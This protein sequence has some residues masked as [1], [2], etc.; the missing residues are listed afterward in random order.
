MTITQIREILERP[1][2]RGTWKSFLKTQFTNN[3]LNVEDRPISLYPN[4]ISDK[5]ISLG[6]YEIDTYSNVGIFEVSLAEHINIT[7]NRVALRNLIKDITAQVSG[8]MVV[9][10]QGEKWRFSYISKRKFRNEDL[11][12]IEDKET[13]PKR[14]T[15]L[16]GKNEKAHTA[17]IRFSTLIEKQKLNLSE[18]LSLDDFEEAFSVEKLSK[19]FFKNYKDTYEDFVQ[20]LTGK[21][22]GK[23]GSRYVELSVGE[24]DWQL[25][26]LFNKEEKQARDFCKRMMGRLVFLY[27]IQKKG[28]LAVGRQKEWGEGNPNYL[29]DLF[30]GS[31]HKD[32]FYA[33][34]LVPLFFN[35]LN[36]E[37]SENIAREERFP[38]LNGGLFDPTQDSKFSKLYLPED[39]FS[40]MFETF[41]N[42]N[43]TIY[44]DAP[45]EHTVAVDPEMLGHIFENLLEDNKDKGAFYTPKEIVHY[46]C[47]ES[48]KAYLFA[49]DDMQFSGNPVA[50]RSIEKV[51]HQ[52]ELTSEEKQYAEKV[53]FK[54]IDALE[55]VRICDPAIGSGA[56]PMG[57]LQEIF[58]AL[59]YLQELKGFKKGVSDADIKKHIIEESIYGVDIDA[60]AVDI[61][62]LRFWLSLVVDEPKPQPL[63]NLDFKIVCAN[64]LI[65]LGELK[66][67]D[68]EGKAAIAVK[69]LE[70]LRHDFFNVSSENKLKL[71][72]GF[73]KIQTDLLALREMST[74]KNYEIYTK[75]NEFNPFEDKPCSWFDASWMFGIKDGFDIVIGNPPY[76]QLQKDGGKLANLYGPV[77]YETFERTGDVYSLFY[78][79]G[80]SLL[81][82]KGV[83]CFITSN[84]WMR[85]HYGLSTR[86]FFAEK[87]HPLLLIDFG[88][89]QVF[90]T[91]TV[92]TNIL[93]FQ[94][95]PKAWKHEKKETI[96]VR[97]ENDYIL[98]DM[99][100][101]DYVQNNSYVLTNL[102]HNSWVVGERDTYDIKGF[103][104][105]QGVPL[106]DWNIVINYGLKT[107]FNEAFIIPGSV[108][109]ELIAEDE[110]SRDV[111]KRVLRGKDLSAW[112]PDFADLWLIYIPWHFPLHEEHHTPGITM[113]AEKEFST[114][115]PAVYNHLLK[116]KPELS[117]RNKAEV[118]IRYEWYALQRFGSNYWKDFEKPKIIFPEI[119][120]YIPFIYDEFDH[121]YSN[122][123]NFIL[124]G[125]KLK[126][127]MCFLNSK[128]F[129]Y[130]FIDN[131]PELQGGSRELRKVFF[132]QIPVKRITEEEELPFSKIVEYVVALKKEK[133]SDHIDQLMMVYFEQIANAMIFELYFTTEF[134]GRSLEIARYI[135]ELH[136][137]D[138]KGDTLYQLR[139]IYISINSDNHPIKQSLFKMLS[140]PQIEVIMNSNVI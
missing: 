122:N 71:E 133:P 120:K 111:I 87:T 63:P 132:E 6:Y 39:I 42:Y 54:I 69:E 29:Y 130:C 96:A 97:I 47:K 107:G 64:T 82:D 83:L 13:S 80:A 138:P 136:S 24:A 66:D 44:E 16:F 99:N 81:N 116:F 134:A 51:I 28:W 119:T 27:F 76:V 18:F 36:N 37:D 135:K 45:D 121:F 2:D 48:L 77:K 12:I 79:R 10:V 58:N 73:R 93:I 38:Y 139:K 41:N 49:R 67:Y 3:K 40:R 21:R 127:L 60:G 9:F 32:D 19:E 56:F 112:Y 34:E 84:K 25:T 124:T 140:I 52:Q 78:E 101:L 30:T 20:F 108:K 95:K 70:N 131:F 59:I 57:I 86:R 113:K 1:Y 75:L 85:A 4:Q 72:R 22:Y 17:A 123:K 23:K 74:P 126:Y 55:Q 46:M 128:L 26:A 98:N 43:F 90:D 31:N 117:A 125:E 110:S 91:A 103:I 137:L 106:K 88:N 105:E 15:Y 61:A 104:E 8:A 65:P 50:K 35:R 11:N 89:V 100:L 109:D 94:N 118:G 92:D 14:Y 114:R 33:R 53:A 102:N 62:R 68:M 5:C 115:Y 129:R 7:R